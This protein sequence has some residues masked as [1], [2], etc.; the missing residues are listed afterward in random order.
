MTMIPKV[1]NDI[2][3]QSFIQIFKPSFKYVISDI[4]FVINK[5]TNIR[6]YIHN[7]AI[8]DVAPIKQKYL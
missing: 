2:H 5:S 8:L 4:Q 3:Y 1:E 6:F 7:Y